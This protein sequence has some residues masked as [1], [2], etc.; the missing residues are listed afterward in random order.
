MTDPTRYTAPTTQ[1]EQFVSEEAIA[2]AVASRFNTFFEVSLGPLA[3]PEHVVGYHGSTAWSARDGRVGVKISCNRTDSSA[4]PT[5]EDLQTNDFRVDAKVGSGEATTAVYLG[6]RDEDEVVLTRFEGVE[7]R[8]HKIAEDDQAVLRVIESFITGELSPT[9]TH[10]AQSVE[11]FPVRDG[12]IADE[13]VSVEAAITT[14]VGGDDL[15]VTEHM[16][17][18]RHD[19]G[20]PSFEAT[21]LADDP[22]S[23]ITVYPQDLTEQ[24]LAAYMASVDEAHNRLVGYRAAAVAQAAG[25][26]ALGSQEAQ[27]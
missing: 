26:T 7:R 25:G 22:D 18:V 6:R 20:E 9:T 4:P 11:V 14:Y 21:W 1:A 23:M 19:E 24:A 5:V 10:T 3:G 27:P 16:L 8:P 17:T 2:A 15:S 12:A 13:G